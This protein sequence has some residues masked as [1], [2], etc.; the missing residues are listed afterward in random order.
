MRN[1]H[2][3]II[4]PQNDF[5]HPTQ[6]ALYVD[7]ADGDMERL[8]VMVRRLTSKINDIHV[9]LDSHHPVDIAHPVFWRDLT[10]QP[11]APFTAITAADVR[12]GQWTTTLPSARNRALS[13]L[14][15]L[16]AT[17]RYPHLI[18]PPHCLIGSAGHN[19]VP[20]LFDALRGWE[21]E[22]F[23]VVDFVT[24]GSNLWTEHFSAVQAEVPDPGDPDTQ[25]NAGLI[26]TLERA[27]LIALAGEAGSHCVANTVRDI[28]SHFSDPAFISKMVLLEDATS[29][30][31][32]FETYQKD[33]IRDMTRAGMQISTT[34]EFLA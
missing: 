8:A 15:A 12:N 2:L 33:F 13:Y 5:C 27:D 32:G 14:E 6:G 23:A 29:P 7:G 16:E 28:A 34:V 3:L 20:G 30:V 25:V 22:R 11:P 19:V 4:D 10:G 1:L 24:K 18:W 17:G 31:K 21:D 9:T 26:D